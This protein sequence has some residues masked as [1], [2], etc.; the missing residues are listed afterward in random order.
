MTSL[1]SQRPPQ[2]R[3]NHAM[4]LVYNMVEIY[5]KS[6]VL[7]MNQR[8]GVGTSAQPLVICIG[9]YDHILRQP[10]G[11]CELSATKYRYSAKI[12]PKLRQF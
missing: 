1:L 7:C 5:F 9:P 2:L 12:P 8:K 3:A 10:R 11:L 6:N 4:L